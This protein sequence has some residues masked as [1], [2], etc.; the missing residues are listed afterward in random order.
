MAGR[1]APLAARAREVKG[2]Q[3]RQL[4][5]YFHFGGMLAGAYDASLADRSHLRRRLGRDAHA[6][7]AY[8]FTPDHVPPE[9]WPKVYRERFALFLTESD[10][11]ETSGRRF[12]SMV[13]VQL[14]SSLDRVGAARALGLPPSHA[15][16]LYNKAMGVVRSRGHTAAFDEQVRAVAAELSVRPDRVD[17]SARRRLLA[18]FR[19]LTPQQWAGLGVTGLA[20][21]PVRRRNAAAWVWSQLTLRDA[22]NSPA[23]SSRNSTQRESHREVYRR[24]RDGDLERLRPAL[25]RLAEE[26]Q[27]GLG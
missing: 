1:L 4:A 22:K 17:Y 15:G 8:A 2:S 18:D 11:T 5:T 26:V 10:L 23:L 13:L 21:T 20:G 9:L 6:R 7:P 16:G 19:E 3:V 12:V 25:E 24:F 14:V 27:A